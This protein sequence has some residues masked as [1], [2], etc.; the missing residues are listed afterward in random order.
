[1]AKKV[2]PKGVTLVE[3]LLAMTLV[4]VAV[5][6]L[7]LTFPK[8]SASISNKRHRWLAS[9]FAASRIQELRAKSYAY[10]P[11]NPAADFDLDTNPDCDCK[12]MDM[13][14]IPDP[15]DGVLV[16]SG[17]TFTRR[18]C[19]NFVDKAGGV[20]NSYCP[21]EPLTNAADKGLKNIRVRVTWS[22]GANTYSTEAE[23][24]VAR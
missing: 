3:L 21:D 20:W 14:T 22:L 1:M 9:N 10:I 11:Y 8:S 6:V 19:I 16:D 13:A 17:I 5:V 2:Y 24:L 23:S 18:V 15:P 4:T 7:S 12:D